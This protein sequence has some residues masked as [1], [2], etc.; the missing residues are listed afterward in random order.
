MLIGFF[1]FC[2]CL[3]RM[4]RTRPSQQEGRGGKNFELGELMRKG[5][6]LFSQA[7]RFRLS[8]NQGKTLRTYD[9]GL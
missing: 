7:L 9:M 4:L 3:S 5:P 8:E 2:V 1:M 6:D